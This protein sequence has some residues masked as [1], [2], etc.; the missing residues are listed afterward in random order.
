MEVAKALRAVKLIYLNTEGGVRGA[1][2]RR[3]AMTV[4]EADAFLKKHRG[5]TDRRKR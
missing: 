3:P 2:G 1:E 4:Q 5:G